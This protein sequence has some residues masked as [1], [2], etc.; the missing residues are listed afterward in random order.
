MATAMHI[1]GEADSIDRVCVY[2]TPSAHLHL[3]SK[4]TSQHFFPQNTT[5]PRLSVCRS[6]AGDGESL[7]DFVLQPQ[8]EA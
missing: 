7:Y 3:S 6:S 8:R 2:P 1:L 5:T 4:P